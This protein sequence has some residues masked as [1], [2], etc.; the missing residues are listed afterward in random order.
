MSLQSHLLS[1]TSWIAALLLFM[2]SAVSL[3]LNVQVYTSSLT[4]VVTDPSGAII[5]QSR[6][7]ATDQDKGFTYS[8]TTG[9]DEP[10]CASQ[11]AAG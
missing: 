3:S 6:V 5:P 8:A 11:P 1:R 9:S 7:E 10:L 2:F 4:G